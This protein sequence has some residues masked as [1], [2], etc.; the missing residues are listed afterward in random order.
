MN[1]EISLP[2]A[3]LRLGLP[4]HAAHKLLL[5][6]KLGAARQIVGRWVVPAAGVEA[7]LERKRAPVAPVAAAAAA[8]A[9]DTAS[10]PD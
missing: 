4:W 8:A 10:A 5:R 1:E 3:A 6:G 9:A 2:Q 7:Y